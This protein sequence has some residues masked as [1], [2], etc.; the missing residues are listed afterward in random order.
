MVL[1]ILSGRLFAG[2][3]VWLLCQEPTGAFPVNHPWQ[4][5]FLSSRPAGRL[6]V[7]TTPTNLP[8]EEEFYFGTRN[9]DAP[10][11]DKRWKHSTLQLRI[12][13]APTSTHKH[14]GNLHDNHPSATSLP[15]SLWLIVLAAK[16]WLARGKA[17]VLMTQQG[18]AW[19][20]TQVRCRWNSTFLTNRA[21]V[22]LLLVVGG[23]ILGSVPLWTTTTGLA[24][25]TAAAPTFL[26]NVMH[27]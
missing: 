19:R 24:T 21:A 23:G 13:K 15:P 26:L 20:W 4:V 25:S 8:K 9:D 12:S 2:L 22:W 17:S 3:C 14:E 6:C 11:N 10:S 16:V 7:A 5:N 27:C 18:L 1:A